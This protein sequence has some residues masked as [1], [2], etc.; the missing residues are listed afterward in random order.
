MRTLKIQYLNLALWEETK[1]AEAANVFKYLPRDLMSV[2]YE[3]E[4]FFHKMVSLPL[5]SRRALCAASLFSVVSLRAS[6]VKKAS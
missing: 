6:V 4:D 5:L 2:A 3:S 1:T